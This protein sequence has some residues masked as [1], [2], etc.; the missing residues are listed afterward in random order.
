MTVRDPRIARV[1]AATL[2]LVVLAVVLAFALG[3]HA[4]PPSDS[5]ARSP[6]VATARA[7][8]GSFVVRVSATGRIG[9]PAGSQARLSFA[10]SGI[11]KSIAVKVGDAVSPG[12]VLASLETS[13]LQ[14]DTA[15]AQAESSA[16]SASYGGGA[17]PG[18]ALMSARARLAVAKVK[19]DAA[20]RRAGS[21]DSDAAAAAA[22]LRQSQEKIAADERALERAQQL[23]TA[24][25]AAQREVD[26][27]RSQLRFDQADDAANRSRL[28]SASAA[29]PG[30]RTQAR[31]D[32]QQAVNDMQ[33]A[34]AQVG[35][36]AAQAQA[37]RGRYAQARRAL[38]GGALKAP[39]SG[40]VLALLKHVGEAVDPSQP[41]VVVGPPSDKSV[42]LS[43]AGNDAAIVRLGDRVSVT[44]ALRRSN[45]SGTVVA[46]VPAVDPTTQTTTVVS[47][48]VPPA[49]AP[50]D[51]VTASI[52]VA[53]RHG[54]LVPATALVN[55][56][57]TGKAVVFVRS[58]DSN[59]HAT[60]TSREVDVDVSDDRTAL[61]RSGVRDGET[62][63]AQGAFDLLAPA[64]G[65]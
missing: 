41:V 42:T 23:F 60:F 38:E 55:D 3:R 1:A 22:A 2:A 59:G 64:G 15:I 6:A 39:T 12:Q 20:Q 7:R 19:L 58:V 49:S 43:V 29:I 40:V 62:V 33:A 37:A 61:L 24:G 17:V 32:Y 50:G 44:D 36:I 54:I 52:D 18:A 5:A 21:A 8:A 46:V 35:V 51:A 65:G 34:Q 28:Q 48:A 13:A 63:A 57:Q 47:S 31:S 4:P 30:A 45:G 9:A 16:A 56:P 25:V 14:I 27:A 26:A 53:T 11:L 10:G